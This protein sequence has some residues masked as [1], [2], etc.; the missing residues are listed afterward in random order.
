[1]EPWQKRHIEDA[2]QWQ[3]KHLN[4]SCGDLESVPEEIHDLHW[5]EALDI[6]VNEIRRLP[7]WLAELKVLR[8]VIAFDN[9]LEAW[10]EGLPISAHWSAIERLGLPDSQVMGIALDW[11]LESPPQRFL[12]LAGLRHLDL[13]RWSKDAEPPHW[14]GPLLA[15]IADRFPLLEVLD[16]F[17]CG[18][19]D[20]PPGVGR[21]A[22]LQ[23][24]ELSSNPLTR[25]PKPIRQLT[26]LQTLSAENSGLR[27]LP[28][29]L[30]AL[31]N[32]CSLS[33]GF[34]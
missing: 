33:I 16:L 18:L 9:P 8:E 2:R 4:L 24:L 7:G 34:N 10:P 3:Y 20:I 27:T 12:A 1:M 6:S 29:W 28:D 11:D 17:S 15:E 26:R 30:F 31:S 32:L 13:G 21:L 19:T 14:I 5:L 23:E 22:H 25:L